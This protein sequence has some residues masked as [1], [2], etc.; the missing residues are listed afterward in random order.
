MGSVKVVTTSCNVISK[1]D[2]K[3][4]TWLKWIWSLNSLMNNI[5]PIHRF[6]WF[7]WLKKESH[8][9]WIIFNNVH[10]CKLIHVCYF[11]LFPWLS[12]KLSPLP[13]LELDS[14]LLRFYGSVRT[15]KPMNGVYKTNIN[16]SF[17]RGMVEIY[18]TLGKI[19][20]CLTIHLG[21]TG[22]GE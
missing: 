2:H 14:P 18:C 17:I 6:K 5:H 16:G 7:D 3:N 12:K 8:M 15:K 4:Y 10:V 21:L 1:I 19:Q 9:T 22:L 20:P 13:N 11:L